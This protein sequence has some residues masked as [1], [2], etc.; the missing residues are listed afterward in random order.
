MR[1]DGYGLRYSLVALAAVVGG[2]CDHLRVRE[3]PGGKNLDALRRVHQRVVTEHRA[4]VLTDA[5]VRLLSFKEPPGA[6]TK[7]LLE[8]AGDFFSQRATAVLDR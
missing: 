4:Q 1:A 6:D 7:L 8:V 2:S 5:S 3:P